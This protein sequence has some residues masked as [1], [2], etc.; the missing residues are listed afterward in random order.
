MFWLSSALGVF[1]VSY[2]ASELI[3]EM[4]HLSEICPPRN[5]SQPLPVCFQTGEGGTEAG[6]QTTTGPVVI[7]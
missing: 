1:N 3:M 5:P 4:A 6:V 7:S 2:V